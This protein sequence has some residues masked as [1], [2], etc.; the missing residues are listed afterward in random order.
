MTDNR[1]ASIIFNS[2]S[3]S[4][5]RTPLRLELWRSK[6]TQYNFK[7]MLVQG[8][9]NIADY[10]SRC[11]KN[12]PTTKLTNIR[13]SAY[14]INALIAH[15]EMQVTD[16]ICRKVHNDLSLQNLVFET[17]KDSTLCKL[18]EIIK[19]KSQ[20]PNSDEFKPYKCHFNELSVDSNNLVLRETQVVLPKSLYLTAVQ[21]AHL[22][23]M[24]AKSCKKLLRHNYLIFGIEKLVDN[25]VD[26]CKACDTNS[27]RSRAHP[28]FMSPIPQ[29]K[30][31]VVAIDF[32]SRTPT[33]EYI[34][35]LICEHS[36]YPVLKLSK[37]MTAKEVIKILINVFDEFGLPR[38]IKSDNGP[39]FIA[40]EF[41][42]FLQDRNITHVKV[43]PIWPQAN[44]LVERFMRTKLTMFLGNN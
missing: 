16:N 15:T 1:A 18:R 4:R 6:L 41:A 35:V 33:G 22:G 42:K 39:C 36:R 13:T 34:L 31:N 24:C 32:S 37:T 5:R 3:D 23:H 44:G 10:L 12:S 19:T 2:Q 14:R 40:N 27:D 30:W 17:N 26:N 11:F 29:D 43:T 9:S 38:S 25:Y 21:K 8:T 7:P 28:L 20:L